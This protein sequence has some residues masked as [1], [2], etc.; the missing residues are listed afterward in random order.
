VTSGPQQIDIV[1]AISNKLFFAGIKDTLFY[2]SQTALPSK[3]EEGKARSIKFQ[4]VSDVL[5]AALKFMIYPIL[6]SQEVFDRLQQLANRKANTETPRLGE[7]KISN[8]V[9]NRQVNQEKSWY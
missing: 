1:L 2:S 7:L 5:L 6:T 4:C 9:I 3:K 8:R